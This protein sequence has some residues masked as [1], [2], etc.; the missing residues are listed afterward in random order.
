MTKFCNILYLIFCLK[1]KQQKS[2]LRGTL[3]SHYESVE[4]DVFWDIPEYSGNEEE[5]EENILRPDGKIILKEEKIIYILEQS[6]PWITNREEKMVEK[7]RK[8]ENILRNIKLE[9]PDY[10]VIQLTF[11]IDCV[12]GYSDTLK[13]NLNQLGFTKNEEQKI[14]FALQKIVI[15]EARMLINH[16]KLITNL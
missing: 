11:I 14:L 6:V 5:I 12:G 2:A 9:N 3:K 13:K 16:F 8:Y 10:N 1:G 15:S 7:I 4:A